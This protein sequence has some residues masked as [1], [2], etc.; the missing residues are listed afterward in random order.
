MKKPLSLY[1]LYC[2]NKQCSISVYH[3]IA[4]I[5]IPFTDENIVAKHKCIQCDHTLFSAMDDSAKK[6]ISKNK[7]NRTLSQETSSDESL[8]QSVR[9]YFGLFFLACFT[10]LY[11]LVYL[12][13]EQFLT[14]LKL[15]Q[16]KLIT[17]R[18]AVPILKQAIPNAHLQ[19][20]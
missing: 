2:I 15:H 9:F 6:D 14:K 11:I 1:F 17:V 7:F 20:N 12:P 18:E 5:K 19:L 16:F 4:E 8:S 10:G 13:F 3:R